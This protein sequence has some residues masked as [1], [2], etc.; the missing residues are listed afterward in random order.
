[1]M[2]NK[3]VLLVS[4]DLKKRLDQKKREGYSLNGYIR[5][6]LERALKSSRRRRA[7]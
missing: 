1:M 7:A 4:N 6:V 3:I 5:S 2:K